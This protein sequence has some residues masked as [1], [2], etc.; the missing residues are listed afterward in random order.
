MA[1]LSS[2]IHDGRWSEQKKRA[3]ASHSVHQLFY[4][5][6][7]DHPNDIFDYRN[8]FSPIGSDALVSAIMNLHLQYG[9]SYV[10]LPTLTHIARYIVRLSI[11]CEKKRLLTASSSSVLPSTSSPPSTHSLEGYDTSYLRSVHSKKQKNM[12]ADMFFLYCLQGIPSV[13]TKTAKQ[14][15]TLFDGSMSSFLDT[16]RDDPNIVAT[17]YKKTYGRSLNKTVVVNMHTLFFPET[18]THART[19]TSSA[20][21]SSSSLTTTTTDDNPPTPFPI[22]I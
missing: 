3:L 16:L 20:S 15:S 11:Q 14:I 17:M 9:I 7:I 18:T 6:Q 10:F 22:S 2:S 21:S 8:R 19:M 5:F 12:T 1:D 13:S 4:I